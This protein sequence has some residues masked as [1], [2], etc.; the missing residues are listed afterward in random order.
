MALL[1]EGG[2]ALARQDLSAAVSLL[3]RA[4]DLLPPGD[5]RHIALA[6]HISDAGIGLWEG[7]R[8]LDALTPRGTRFLA[9]SGP[10]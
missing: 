10:R 1:A 4:R 8:A 6:L 3:E 5:A 2:G 9:T 7:R